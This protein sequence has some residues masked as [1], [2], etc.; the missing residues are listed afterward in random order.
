MDLTPSARREKHHEAWVAAVEYGYEDKNVTLSRA[1]LTSDDDVD[2]EVELTVGEYRIEDDELIESLITLLALAEKATMNP[3]N[4]KVPVEN[5]RHVGKKEINLLKKIKF[6][7]FGLLPS[8]PDFSAGVLEKLTELGLR[9]LASSVSPLEVIRREFSEEMQGVSYLGP[10]RSHPTRHYII[11]GADKNSVG[12]RGE[13]TPQLLW[14]QKKDVIPRINQKF[15]EFGIPY[16]ID[17]KSAGNLLTGDIVVV[18]LSD[19]SNVV[20]SPSDVGFGIGQLLPILVEG[21]VSSER[22]ICVEQ[23]EIHL[24]PRMQGHIADF[25][26][27]TALSRGTTARAGSAASVKEYGGNQWIVETHSEGLILRLQTRVKEGLHPDFVS[28]LYVEPMELVGARV[29]RL[30]LD[31]QGDFIDEWPDGFFEESFQEIFRRRR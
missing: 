11:S 12:T 24:H 26:I 18:Q 23:P 10:L 30:R 6:S 29:R 7:S 21:V 2:L 15:R 16:A 4:S 25:L 1:T 3:E 27:D 8:R 31:S 17:I 19:R 28:V 20:V 5:I 22:T 14:R 13:R 9:I